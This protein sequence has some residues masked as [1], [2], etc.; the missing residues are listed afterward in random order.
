MK[1]SLKDRNNKVFHSKYKR[2]KKLNSQMGKVKRCGWK[3][4][5]FAAKQVYLFFTALQQIV[6]SLATLNNT[7][8]SSHSLQGSGVEAQHNCL[9]SVPQS[10]YPGAGQDWELIW[11]SEFPCKPAWLLAEL[12]SLYL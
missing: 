8:L 9:L 12:I 11:D 2:P 4:K 3:K 1:D 7:H 6:T 5:S 10:C